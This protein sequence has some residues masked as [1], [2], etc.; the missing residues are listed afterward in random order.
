MPNDLAQGD[1]G[2]HSLAAFRSAPVLSIA[3]A[4]ISTAP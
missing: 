1:I 2:H 3:N 4:P